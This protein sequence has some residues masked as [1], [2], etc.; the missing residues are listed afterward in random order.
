MEAKD[1]SLAERLSLVECVTS[2]LEASSFQRHFR[3]NVAQCMN[4]AGLLLDS[5]SGLGGDH[6][7]LCVK[8]VSAL[9]GISRCF[10][11]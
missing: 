2:V 11:Y 8:G 5:L 4:F 9:Q 10:S 6:I 1:W 3:T 7:T